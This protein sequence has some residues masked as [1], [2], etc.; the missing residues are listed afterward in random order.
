MTSRTGADPEHVEC[1]VL[2]V[3]AGPTGLFAAY[4]A[5]FR[6]HR[7]AVVDSL[8]E[9]GGQVTAMYPEK[10]I[11]DVAGFPAVKGRDLVAGLVEQAASADPTY[12]LGRTALSLEHRDDGVRVGLD[13]GTTVSAGAVLVTAGIGRFT[14]RPLPAGEGWLGRGLEFFVPRFEPYADKDVVIVGGGDSAFDWAVHLEP[15]ARSVTLVHRRAQF[16]AHERTVAQVRASSVRLVTEAEVLALRAAPGDPDGPLGEVELRQ[17]EETTVL[18]CQAVVAALGFVADLGPI[19]QWGIEVDK[20]HVVVDP[21]MRTN[22]PRVFAAGDITE[23]PG[24]VRLIAV[25]F[26]EAA[27]AVNNA[28]V[29]IDPGAKVFPGHSSEGS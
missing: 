12:L 13:D 27:T 25:G 5:G 21:S 8:P 19:Q 24:K 3:G 26:G 1:D 23:H 7:V 20:R 10:L 22:L 18:P 29:A 14:P 17:G 4:Y 2:V 6:G 9:L 15:V 28:T 16:R 11:L